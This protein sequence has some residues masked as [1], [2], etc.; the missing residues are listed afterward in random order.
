M[1]RYM[2]PARSKRNRRNVGYVFP[3]NYWF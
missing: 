3:N 1:L 2:L